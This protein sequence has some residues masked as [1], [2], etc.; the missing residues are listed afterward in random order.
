MISKPSLSLLKKME[1][2]ANI[3]T[4]GSVQLLASTEEDRHRHVARGVWNRELGNINPEC[5]TIA[6]RVV[7]RLQD[8]EFLGRW[9]CC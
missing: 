5:L 9:T 3:S 8:L 4:V 7:S 6:S 1:E 2:F